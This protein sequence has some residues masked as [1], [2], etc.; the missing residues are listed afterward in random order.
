MARNFI[1]PRE[2]SRI[3]SETKKL[4]NKKSGL[5]EASIA[6]AISAEKSDVVQVLMGSL[7]T[8]R[9]TGNSTNPQWRLHTPHTRKQ[10]NARL[11]R[12]SEKQTKQV[13]KRKDASGKS[14]LAK[15]QRTDIWDSGVGESKLPTV[16]SLKLFKWQK[17]A[18]EAW[19]ANDHRGVVNA[20]TGAGKTRLAM[21]AIRLQ[22]SRRGYVVVVVPTV[23]LMDQWYDSIKRT[24]PGRKIARLGGDYRQTLK[25]AKILIALVDSGRRWSFDTPRES[26]C[27]LVADEC[28]R[29][30]SEVSRKVLEERFDRRLGLTATHER[31]DDLHLTVLNPY[32]GKVVYSYGFASA[33]EQGVIARLRIARVQCDFSKKSRTAYDKLTDDMAGYIRTLEPAF[34]KPVTDFA[35]LWSEIERISNGASK[36]AKVARAWIGAWSDRRSLVFESPEKLKVLDSLA[37]TIEDADRVLI[38]VMTT[39]SADLVA[40]QIRNLGIT[41]AAHSSAI[42]TSVREDM[43]SKFAGGELKVLVAAMTLDEGVDVPEA[44]LAIV[45]ASSQQRRQMIQRVGRILRKKSD[46]RFAR[47][48]HIYF[49]DTFEDLDAPHNELNFLDI[50][51]AAEEVETFRLP[52]QKAAIRRFLMPKRRAKVLK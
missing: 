37:K 6:R 41:A 43:L 29:Y 15:S 47:L 14:R 27:L 31:M 3:K 7:E 23:A 4:L 45:L 10:A 49:K 21:V 12:E 35:A 16:A 34:Q 33:I 46:K 40:R 2:S 18:F 1:S 42:S 39:E 11:K 9:A 50:Y 36:Y 51:E 30:A 48:V 44:D 38:F 19:V 17:A 25:D 26:S 52:R 22:L 8:F 13:E 28:H 20:V 24:F 32:F 5:T